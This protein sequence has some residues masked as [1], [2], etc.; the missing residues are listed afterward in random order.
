MK[1]EEFIIGRTYD[2]YY[3]TDVY[4]KGLVFQGIRER[5][6]YRMIEADRQ[7]GEYYIV[8][9]FIFNSNNMSDI[10]E[11]PEEYLQYFTPREINYWA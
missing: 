1:S 5:K 7:R 9:C 10:R 2:F 8:F 3:S 4:Y 6:N 11:W